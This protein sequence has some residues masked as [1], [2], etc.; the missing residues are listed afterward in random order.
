MKCTFLI[1]EVSDLSDNY[2]KMRI[3]AL[4]M[5]GEYW[6]IYNYFTHISKYENI[7]CFIYYVQRIFEL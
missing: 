6:K 2:L 3:C 1:F 4:T 7:V 5:N